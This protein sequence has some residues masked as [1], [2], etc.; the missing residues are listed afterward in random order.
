MDILRA[1]FGPASPGVNTP[2]SACMVPANLTSSS[3]LARSSKASTFHCAGNTP[4]RYG[5][6][7]APLPQASASKRPWTFGVEPP[8]SPIRATEN[9]GTTLTEAILLYTDRLGPFSVPTLTARKPGWAL[10]AALSLTL[11][12]SGLC[13]T[14]SSTST[15]LPKSGLPV[16]PLPIRVTSV[17]LPAFR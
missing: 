17:S 10:A 5:L 2:V 9:S 6:P 3:S 13:S 7:S 11:I 16:R 15:P 8:P 14:T 4:M 12:R 1:G